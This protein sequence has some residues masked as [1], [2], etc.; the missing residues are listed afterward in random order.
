[1]KKEVYSQ[2]FTRLMTLTRQK[3]SLNQTSGTHECKG[4]TGRI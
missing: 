2:Y 1:V 3:E 4:Q